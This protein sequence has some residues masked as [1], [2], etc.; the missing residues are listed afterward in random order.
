MT[1]STTAAGSFVASAKMPLLH[2]CEQIH[3]L[4]LVFRLAKEKPEKFV[5]EF[6]N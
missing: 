2:M 5:F 3:Q 1:P 6:T 4:H